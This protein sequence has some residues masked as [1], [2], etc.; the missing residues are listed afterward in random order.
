[1]RYYTLCCLIVFL[2]SFQID[3]TVGGKTESEI[4]KKQ[5]IE[6]I[7]SDSSMYYNIAKKANQKTSLL[8]N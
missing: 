3:N 6:L 7:K 4:T 1:M 8:K 5:Y 2:Y